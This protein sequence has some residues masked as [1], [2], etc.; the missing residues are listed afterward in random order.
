VVAV[1]AVLF[2]P[3]LYA[4]APASAA[5]PAPTSA[6]KETA[7]AGL[8]VTSGNTDTSTLNLG[9]ELVYDPKS[10]NM[11]KS[12]GL[13]L[14]G[15]T[16]GA[17]TS[18]RIGV[19]GRDE[20]KLR[21]RAYTFA[22]LQFV[23]DRFKDIDYLV[24][25]AAGVGYRVA[26]SA[27]TKLSFDIGVGRIWEKRP[28]VDVSRTGAVTFAEKLAQTL[29]STTSLTQSLSALY[30]TTDFG[31]VLYTFD[32]TLSASVNAHIQMKLEVLDTYKN[33]V[34]AAIEKNDVM[35]VVGMVFKR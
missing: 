26:D 17:L 15:K 19:N 27:A 16:D 14:R 10:R 20:Y 31:D 2:A 30:K 23:R 21:D 29:S 12:D 22:Q 32:T 18:E 1:L 3:S 11:V 13:F 34:P 8:A 9:Y 35:L 6:W 33:L 25:P 28:A 24:S 5:P 7:S 4:Q